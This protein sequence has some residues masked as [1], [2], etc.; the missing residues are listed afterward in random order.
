MTER[1]DLPHLDR[2]TE[3]VTC[4]GCRNE[5]EAHLIC[6]HDLWPGPCCVDVCCPRHHEDLGEAA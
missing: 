2:N 4:E 3:L 6:E 5:I 1:Y